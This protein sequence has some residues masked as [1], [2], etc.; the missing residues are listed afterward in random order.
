MYRDLLWY[1]YNLLCLLS[2][3]VIYC[4]NIP[5]A[6]KD[7]NFWYNNQ[8]CIRFAETLKNQKRWKYVHVRTLGFLPLCLCFTPMGGRENLM[9][10]QV[11]PIRKRAS[12]KTKWDC[13]LFSVVPSSRYLENAL[14]T[15]WEKYLPRQ[16]LDATY[17]III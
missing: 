11:S 5:F 4:G 17:Q 15:V 13:F 2:K 9:K 1:C 3:S 6:F 10:I 8:K 12:S 14:C 7:F 16:Y